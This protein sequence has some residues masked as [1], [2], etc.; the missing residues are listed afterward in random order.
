MLLENEGA[1]AEV[2]Q[3]EAAPVVKSMDDTIRD[4]LRSLQDKSAT[5]EVESSAPQTLEEKAQRIRDNQGKFSTN[6]IKPVNEAAPVV[7]ETRAP[8]TWK[9]EAAEKWATVDPVIRA[10]VER[11]EA[12][13]FKGIEQYK[14]QAQF[15]QNMQSAIAP[16]MQTIQSLGITPDQAIGELMQADARLRY[17]SPQ[18][19]H[20]Y[21]AQLAQSYGINLSMAQNSPQIDPNMDYLQQQVQHLQNHIQNQQLMGQRQEE[22]SLYSEINNFSSDPKHSHFESVREYMAALLQAGQAKDLSDA[23]EQAIYANPTTRAAV[24]AEQQVSAKSEASKKAQAAKSSASINVRARPSM[25]V[26]QPIGTMDETIRATLRRL[27][28]A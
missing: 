22:A 5:Q 27:Q 11:R 18:E 15:A 14:S 10:E 12:D 19:K 25:P 17:G 23:Y 1:T 21:F 26:S 2:E 28:G 8:N 6:E 13:F 3:L 20:S 16:H 24:L 7:A 4:T 9:K